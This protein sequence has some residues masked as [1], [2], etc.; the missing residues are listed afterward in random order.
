VTPDSDF[1]V[2]IFFDIKYVK[3]VQDIAMLTTIHDLSNSVISYD[4][5]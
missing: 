5:E 2:V 3:T 4:L 1:K